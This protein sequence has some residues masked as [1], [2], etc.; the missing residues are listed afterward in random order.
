ML[1]KIKSLVILLFLTVVL[2]VIIFFVSI[3]FMSKAED[4]WICDN[5]QWVK[6]GN[7]TTE[8][9]KTPCLP[10]TPAQTTPAA[11]SSSVNEPATPVVHINETRLVRPAAG[12][13]LTSP[14]TISGTMPGSWFF[15]ANAR[16]ELFD[17]T[18]YM[19]ASGAVQAKSD[20]MIEGP[21]E[22]EGR[23]SFSKPS[24]ATGTIVLRNDN[25]SGLPEN[26]KKEIYPVLFGATVK[27][28]FGNDVMNPEMTDCALVYGVDRPIQSTVTV[29]KAAIEELLKGP[30]ETELAS[31]YR[32]QINKAVKINKLTIENG[33]ASVDFSKDI[34]KGLGG[35]CRVSA[36]RSQIEATLKQ[37]PSVKKV[38]ISVDGRVDDALQP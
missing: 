26:E 4:G 11:S 1:S 3:R 35:S 34:E 24:T 27:V 20:W 2:G 29:G 17:S 7:P 9:P 23:L 31:G 38:I 36:I 5:G 21:V 32:T 13:V 30:S 25:P 37:F 16:V 28:F 19:L 18:G 10:N 14:Y 22:F 8:V 6:H 15:E 33:T 12:E